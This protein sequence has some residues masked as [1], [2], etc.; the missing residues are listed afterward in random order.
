MSIIST[1]PSGKDVPEIILVEVPDPEPVLPWSGGKQEQ[2]GYKD[3]K[4]HGSR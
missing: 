2:G 3:G 1:F 4:K